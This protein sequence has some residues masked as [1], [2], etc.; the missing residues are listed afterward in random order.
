MPLR[1]ELTSLWI[2]V[3]VNCVTK[4]TSV[5]NITTGRILTATVKKGVWYED[6]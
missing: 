6:V 5:R 1:R 4:E 3:G 2:G